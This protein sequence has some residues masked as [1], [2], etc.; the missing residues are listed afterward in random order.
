VQV[1]LLPKDERADQSHAVALRMR[2]VVDSIARAYGAAVK[3][4]EIP[5]GPPVQS[6]LVAEVYGPT[7]DAQIDAA[8]RVR[9]VFEATDGVVDVDWTVDAPHAQLR[10]KLRQAGVEPIAVVATDLDNARLYF[11]LRPSKMAIVSDPDCATH[12]AFGVPEPAP[13]EQL[14]QAMQTTRVN[15]NGALPEALPIVEAGPAMAK[16]D[17]Y[18]TTATDERDRERHAMQLKGQFLLDRDGVVRW[19]NIECAREGLAGIGKF[20]TD[21]ELL[22]AVKALA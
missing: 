10:A 8:R 6:T 14:M 22:E 9:A 7:Y 5:P 21:A 20:P 11:K 4:A 3:V 15:P 12:R 16:L 18:Q 2:P 1:N 17:G 19:S 13:S